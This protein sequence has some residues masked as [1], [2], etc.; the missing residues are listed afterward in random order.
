MLVT[1]LFKRGSCWGCEKPCAA[2]SPQE[3]GKQPCLWITPE[4]NDLLRA[5]LWK[6]HGTVKCDKSFYPRAMESLTAPHLP[7]SMPSWKY[8]N[9]C[10]GC[11]YSMS[12]ISHSKKASPLPLP[13][14]IMLCCVERTAENIWQNMILV[15]RK[16]WF[17]NNCWTWD[18]VTI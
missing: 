6:W 11:E 4:T 1:A 3:D 5:N 17:S 16:L 14:K 18:W 7:L 12:V 13:C 9:Y 8:V 10:S 2:A 15:V